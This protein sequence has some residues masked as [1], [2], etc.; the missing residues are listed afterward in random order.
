MVMFKVM[1][2]LCKTN[3]INII[4]ITS[5][6]D[7]V[8][9]NNINNNNI[10]LFETNKLDICKNLDIYNEAKGG[11]PK[12]LKLFKFFNLQKTPKTSIYNT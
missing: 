5:D 11:L 10:K 8:M 1:T 3:G 4:G 6:G 9:N 12:E 7:K 2:K